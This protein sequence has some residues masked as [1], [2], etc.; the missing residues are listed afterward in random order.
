M[1]F[2][3]ELVPWISEIK[4]YLTGNSNKVGELKKILK[5]VDFSKL[6]YSTKAKLTNMFDPRCEITE[7]VFKRELNLYFNLLESKKPMSIPIFSEYIEWV[8]SQDI[9]K[10]PDNVFEIISSRL[11]KTSAEVIPEPINDFMTKLPSEY[12]KSI[13]NISNARLSTLINILHNTKNKYADMP[14]QCQFFIKNMFKACAVKTE[15]SDKNKTDFRRLFREDPRAFYSLFNKAFAG[16]SAYETWIDEPAKKMTYDHMVDYANYQ[17]FVIK[18]AGYGLNYSTFES[19]ARNLG[20]SRFPESRDSLSGDKYYLKEPREY[21]DYAKRLGELFV[22]MVQEEIETLGSEIKDNKMQIS[23][24]YE[25]TPTNKMKKEVENVFNKKYST[26]QDLLRVYSNFLVD[27]VHLD[28]LT[29]QSKRDIFTHKDIETK[30]QETEAIK[31][32]VKTAPSDEEISVENDEDYEEFIDKLEEGYQISLAERIM[33]CCCVREDLP[34]LY[35]RYNELLEN[36]ERDLGLER[37]IFE[38]ESMIAEENE[39]LEEQEKD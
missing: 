14:V 15:I 34:L 35:E 29:G 37:A 18:N 36:G 13:D 12:A 4:S 39:N 38:L 6:D 8:Y 25:F 9:S 27:L 21:K 7:E 24:I 19:C 3:T 32:S 16:F 23:K 10:M 31:Q 11:L 1:K 22:E 26:M 2:K 5:N 20:L 17:E 28:E 30:A 33:N